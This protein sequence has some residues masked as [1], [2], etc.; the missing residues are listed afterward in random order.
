MNKQY[1]EEQFEKC[2]NFYKEE[3]VGDL[4]DE[5]FLKQAIE[6]IANAKTDFVKN[7]LGGTK[8]ALK[9][10]PTKEEA[11]YDIETPMF[12]KFDGQQ[13]AL[14]FSN[15]VEITVSKSEMLNGYLESD[16]EYTYK[17][18]T[19]IFRE[20]TKVVKVFTRI[21]KLQETLSWSVERFLN[22]LSAYLDKIRTI[23]REEEATE[24]ATTTT[25]FSIE[26]YDFLSMS[27]RNAWSSCYNV[28]GCHSAAPM[29][30]AMAKDT[31]NVKFYNIDNDLIGRVNVVMGEAGYLI[32]RYYYKKE[33]YM[34]SLLSRISVVLQAHY[35]QKGIALTNEPVLYSIGSTY[36]D[37][38]YSSMS[39][40]DFETLEYGVE[41]PFTL[42]CH[43]GCIQTQYLFGEEYEMC[44]ECGSVEPSESFY[45]GLC[46]AC[47]ESLCVYCDICGDHHLLED[48]RVVDGCYYCVFCTQDRLSTCDCCGELTLNDYLTTTARGD[49]VC[50][51]C[52]CNN[53][54]VCDECGEYYNDDCF[55]E[56]GDE[57][58]C[59]GCYEET[60]TKC[61]R[62]GEYVK[63][64]DLKEHCELVF[65][66]DCFKEEE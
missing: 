54:T 32:G 56:V 2:N 44:E 33:N 49:V 8:M 25:V 63:N 57:L 51:D 50:E 60:H 28:L 3:G 55:M 43:G 5:S 6:Y 40:G 64:E 9:G 4:I 34:P 58:V 47:Q 53:Y 62:C 13:Y 52:L 12:V 22:A 24:E 41:E 17:D 59:K 29:S 18:K 1:L 19:I 38:F 31:I 7:F 20:G 61:D 30:I 26:P 15:K 21:L 11:I 10:V 39:K 23:A 65:C 45:E 42:D 48:S 27:P 37:S 36:K 16:R 46:L 35:A 14:S 66:N